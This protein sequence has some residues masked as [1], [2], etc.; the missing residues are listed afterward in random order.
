MQFDSTDQLNAIWALPH[1]P[2]RSCFAVRLVMSE[3]TPRNPY[4]F[5]PKPRL[6]LRVGVTGHRPKPSKF[7]PASVQW[8]KKRL[9]EVF[10]GIDAALAVFSDKNRDF[11][12]RD[13]PVVRLVSGM[14][15]G[16]DQIAV[17]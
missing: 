5:P 15:E 7:P 16:V 2:L 17:A 13:L 12:S 8:V 1:Y 9:G 10:A 11:Y 4:D 6:T 3:T 14:A